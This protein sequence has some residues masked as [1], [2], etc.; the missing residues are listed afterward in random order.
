MR[1]CGGLCTS[2]GVHV[3][4][5]TNTLQKSEGY[6]AEFFI[7]PRG[8]FHIFTL[9]LKFNLRKFANRLKNIPHGRIKLACILNYVLVRA[10]SCFVLCADVR[11]RSCFVLC[12]DVRARS[13]FVLCADVRGSAC[14]VR[15]TNLYHYNIKK[16]W[17]YSHA[18]W[19]NMVFINYSSLL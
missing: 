8:F 7:N 15:C 12:A 11:A 9:N 2:C 19:I 14:F 13:C 17:D 1:A 3:Y 5:I 10:R 4:T 16:A 6:I 18:N